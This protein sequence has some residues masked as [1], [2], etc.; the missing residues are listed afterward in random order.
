MTPAAARDLLMTCLGEI[1]PDADLAALPPGA[2]LRRDLDLDS[3]DVFN[4]VAALA[5]Q[6]GVEI[7]DRD[8]AQLVSVDAAVA[9]LAGAR[10]ARA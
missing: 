2:D 1:A 4:L 3:M 8:A 5:E 6:G 10:P 9:Y 7:P